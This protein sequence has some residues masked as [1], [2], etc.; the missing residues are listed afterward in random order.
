M[1]LSLL[2]S[3]WQHFEKKRA[4]TGFQR[5]QI[6]P[7]LENCHKPPDFDKVLWPNHFSYKHLRH[8]CGKTISKSFIWHLVFWNL[9]GGLWWLLEKSGLIWAF[10]ISRNFFQFSPRFFQP[11]GKYFNLNYFDIKIFQPVLHFSA[12]MK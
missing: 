6:R 4:K 3:K 9:P 5:W 12:M 2:S 8:Y 11:L 10:Q 7:F 1:W